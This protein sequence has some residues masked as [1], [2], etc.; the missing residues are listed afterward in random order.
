[1]PSQ[2]W[3]DAALYLASALVFAA[4]FMKAIVP[5][6]V[7]AIASNIAFVGYAI[8]VWNIPILILHLALLPLNIFR[9][10]QHVKLAQAVR[11]AID[12]DAH[13]ESLLPFMDRQSRP[14]GTVLFE[15]GD[16]A[17]DM[18]FLVA[19]R[20]RFPEI[21]VTIGAGSLFGE[22]APFLHGRSRTSSAICT[23]ACEI[24]TLSGARVQELAITQPAFG[25]FLTKLIARRMNDNN[26]SLA[27]LKEAP[28]EVRRS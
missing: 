22:I 6:R 14:R 28:D 20:V 3:I 1:M 26:L 10:V 2:I 8:G 24:C 21:D 12:G 9:T 15:K 4:F 11:K 27:N 16:R 19:G 17:D 23:E 25:L 7:I 5:L 18:Y 13:I